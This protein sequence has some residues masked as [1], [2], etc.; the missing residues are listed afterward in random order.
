MQSPL[1]VRR[2]ARGQTVAHAR[3]RIRDR[4]WSD[5]TGH[6]EA[7]GRARLGTEVPRRDHGRARSTCCAR[8]AGGG[9]GTDRHGIPGSVLHELRRGR[10]SQERQ[11][12]QRSPESA[13]G[14]ARG[15]TGGRAG[16]TGRDHAV[17]GSLPPRPRGGDRQPGARRA[18]RGGE[19]GTIPGPA[20]ALHH[21][22]PSF[23]SEHQGPRRNE[24]GPASSPGRGAGAS[25][26]LSYDECG[27]AQAGR[28]RDAR[29]GHRGAGNLLSSG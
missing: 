26:S 11:D 23:R 9:S 17:Q 19:L 27:R 16:K 21:A 8:R 20:T 14:V 29:S 4:A 15:A 1:V 5:R 7:D 3:G 28:T 24:A 6:V 10:G 22:V 13:Q 25:G 18:P 2:H 12:H